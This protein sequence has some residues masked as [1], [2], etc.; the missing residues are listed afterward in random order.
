MLGHELIKQ[1]EAQMNLREIALLD[2]YGRK[3]RHDLGKLAATYG[4]SC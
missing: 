3:L 1:W 4:A 2:S